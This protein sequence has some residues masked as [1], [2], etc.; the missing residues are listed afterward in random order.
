[1]FGEPTIVSADAGLNR[2][3]FQNEGRMFESSYPSSIDGILGKWSMLVLNG[4]IHRDMRNISLN[5]LSHSRLKNYLIKEVERHTLIV[6]NSWI[7]NSTF[8]A[9]DE[10]K[11]VS[12]I[13][14]ISLLPNKINFNHLFK[15][16][17]Q[18][19]YLD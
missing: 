19:V 6:L 14:F 7:E 8:S 1:M 9:Q 4:D 15:L 3:I 18:L 5:F 16:L 10:A 2:F 17:V 11:K 13:S 12:F